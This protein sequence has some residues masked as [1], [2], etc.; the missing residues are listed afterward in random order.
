[1]EPSPGRQLGGYYFVE[2]SVLAATVK[3]LTL[4]ASSGSW[5]QRVGVRKF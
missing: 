2:A 1:M 3:Q 5:R 4:S